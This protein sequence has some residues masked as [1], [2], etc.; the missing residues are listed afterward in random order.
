ML[1][2]RDLPP[3]KLSER[4]EARLEGSLRREREL[5]AHLEG[6]PVAE[7]PT[8]EGLTG[9]L[10]CQLDC[11]RPEEGGSCSRRAPHLLPSECPH[12]CRA[13]R[14]VFPLPSPHHPH[15]PQFAW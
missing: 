4:L 3:C 9:A 13:L 6:R 1:T 15:T 10:S 8:A 5:R 7:V 14:T 12:I 11:S 2:A